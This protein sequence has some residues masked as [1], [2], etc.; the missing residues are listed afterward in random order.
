[1]ASLPIEIQ[2]NLNKLA[3][4]GT[5]GTLIASNLQG[6][7]LGEAI[8]Y[9]QACSENKILLESLTTGEDHLRTPYSS[10]AKAL[11]LIDKLSLIHI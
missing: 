2:I 9:Y 3:I 7:P 11:K 5:S 1:M 4:S 6:E 8:P 10:L